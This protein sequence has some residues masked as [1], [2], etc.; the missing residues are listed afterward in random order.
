[1]S[2]FEVLGWIAPV[3][4]AMVF[5][6]QVVK[7]FVSKKTTGLSPVSYMVVFLGSTLYMFWGAAKQDHMMQ[8]TVAEAI[9]S[10]S[11]LIIIFFIF[12]NMKKMQ[13]FYIALAWEIFIS[14]ATITFIAS[15]DIYLTPE[16]VM[17]IT[18]IGGLSIALAFMPQTVRALIT[19]D[20][21]NI[22]IM[23][24][25]TLFT[26][27]TLLGTYQLGQGKSSDGWV[28]TLE[29]YIGA[30]IEFV[31][32]AW[33]IPQFIMKIMDNMKVKKAQAS[34]TFEM[35]AIQKWAQKENRTIYQRAAIWEWMHSEEHIDKEH[36]DQV[37]DR[38]K[39]SHKDIDKI[40]DA[41]NKKEA[42][43]KSYQAK[44]NTQKQANK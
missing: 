5:L 30:T 10:V 39:L 19:K 25:V 9:V 21:K 17:P 29:R 44:I 23:T 42:Y 6:P 31:A 2:A 14:V 34:K 24:V 40:M 43:K 32:A 11:E 15:S 20:V 26:A 36:L 4:F 28:L 8:L 27:V 7:I 18:I 1:M 13:Y 41:H 3:I 22:S 38:L 12:K 35:T 37:A 33:S 16:W